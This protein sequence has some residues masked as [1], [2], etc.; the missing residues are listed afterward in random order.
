MTSTRSKTY[1]PEAIANEFLRIAR[2]NGDAL[3]P[4]K[5]LKLVYYAHGWHLGL[6][7]EPLLNEAVEA[8]RYGPVV[9]SLWGK[10]RKYEGNPVS[11]LLPVEEKNGTVDDSFVRSLIEEVWD[12]YGDFRAMKL[13]N[14]THMRG[15]PWY[16]VK[17]SYDGELPRRVDI[18]NAKIQEYFQ[19]LLG[20]S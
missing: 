8:W 1:E 12:S 15:T 2:E 16:E 20:Q 10:M 5:L 19:S 14:M 17:Q 13:S 7:K 11:D 3:S 4:M 18:P 9:P 6:T